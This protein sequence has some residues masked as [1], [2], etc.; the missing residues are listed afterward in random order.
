MPFLTH[1]QECRSCPDEANKRMDVFLIFRFRGDREEVFLVAEPA[2]E[3]M[4]GTATFP[5]GAA[6]VLALR[7]KEQRAIQK[8]GGLLGLPCF[9]ASQMSFTL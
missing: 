4:L 9:L 1:D 6:E 5:P 2:H 8:G 7:M 3:H